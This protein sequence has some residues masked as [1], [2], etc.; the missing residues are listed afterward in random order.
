MSIRV[1]IALVLLALP[2]AGQ[3]ALR[4]ADLADR[5]AVIEHAAHVG[6]VRYLAELSLELEAEKG[7]GAAEALVPYYAALAAYR[8]AELDDDIDFRVGVLL[9]RCVENA[10]R[11]LKVDAKFAEAMALIGAC[12]GLAA[13]RQPLSAIIAGNFSARELKRAMAIAPENPRVRLLNA[14]T[15]MRRFEDDDR[16]IQ[17][18]GDLQAAL[19]AFERPA[20]GQPD[21][22]GWGEEHAHLW[23]A[24]ALRLDGDLQGARDHVEQAHLLSPAGSSVPERVSALR[25]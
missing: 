23:L 10:R 13:S 20:A 22:P 1:T 24:R 19:A 8:A 7:R 17:A 4:M 12:H 9:D 14:I 25:R 3:A 16:R 15:V 18:R 21:L 2:M 6:D 11:A 5:E